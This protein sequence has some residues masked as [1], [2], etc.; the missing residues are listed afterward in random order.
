MRGTPAPLEQ[1]RKDAAI[2]D[3][4]EQVAELSRAQTTAVTKMEAALDALKDAVCELAPEPE[5]GRGGKAP[6]A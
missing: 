5:R 6:R 4:H 2:R 3:L 1:R